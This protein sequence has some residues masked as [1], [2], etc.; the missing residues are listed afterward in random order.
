MAAPPFLWAP[1]SSTFL[2]FLDLLQIAHPAWAPS[3]LYARR[4]TCAVLADVCALFERDL[5]DRTWASRS[6]CASRRLPYAASRRL[7][8]IVLKHDFPF[9]G[10]HSAVKVKRRTHGAGL[11]GGNLQWRTRSLCCD[12]ECSSVQ[13][14]HR[15]IQ[16]VALDLD[17]PENIH[18][19]TDRHTFLLENYTKNGRHYKLRNV[20]RCSGTGRGVLL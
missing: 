15:L 6:S 3:R 10:G 7:P 14:H 5:C 13:C 1:P 12:L 20:A 9:K 4:R 19:N 8:R 2:T 16:T 11:R 17:R 18:C